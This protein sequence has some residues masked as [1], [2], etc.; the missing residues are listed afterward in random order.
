[1]QKE[2]NSRELK[3]LKLSCIFACIN[4]SQIFEIQEE[5]IIQAIDTVEFLSQDFKQFLH[6]RPKTG[7]K[8]EQAYKFL[9]ENE[10]LEFTKTK[11]L[12]F[13]TKQFGFS[14]EP[15]RNNFHSAITAIWEI[16]QEDGYTIIYY[17][18]KCNHG[19]FF[20]LVKNEFAIANT[21][22]QG[23]IRHSTYDFF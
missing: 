4:H 18:N 12:N 13:F 11:L 19:T 17:N 8:Y 7:D 1:M 3:A 10:G 20:S 23:T 22:Y 9:R 16:A 2:I 14:R 5:D 15:L 21:N 6:Y